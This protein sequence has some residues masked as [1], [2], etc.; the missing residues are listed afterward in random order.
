M[1][2]RGHPAIVQHYHHCGCLSAPSS[3]QAS[4]EGIPTPTSLSA[5]LSLSLSVPLCLSASVSV[6]LSLCSILHVAPSAQLGAVSPQGTTLSLRAGLACPESVPSTLHVGQRLSAASH[7]P[8]EV[9]THGGVTAALVR[10]RCPSALCVT[11][12]GKAQRLPESLVWLTDL[13]S[14]RGWWVSLPVPR[15]S[16]GT[17]TRLGRGSSGMAICTAGRS[18]ALA[19]LQRLGASGRVTPGPREV[20]PPLLHWCWPGAL[21]LCSC[22]KEPPWHHAAVWQSHLPT[23]GP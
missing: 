17:P 1:A 14:C 16:A 15:A 7:W 22:G 18:K 19:S 3:P 12:D 5:S 21:Q 8:V 6:S 4:S 2:G 9:W 20:L 11:N 10:G 13:Y 23:G